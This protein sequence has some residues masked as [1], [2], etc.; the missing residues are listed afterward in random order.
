MHTVLHYEQ[1][2][3]IKSTKILPTYFRSCKIAKWY[4]AAQQANHCKID[5]QIGTQYCKDAS[6]IG[7]HDCES[8]K[9]F[10]NACSAYLKLLG[11]KDGNLQALFTEQ[12]FMILCML[13]MTPKAL[14]TI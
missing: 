9:Q 3:N 1:R 12:G 5:L 4:T 7:K 10:I 14:I 6:T 2:N 11:V 8:V 13:G